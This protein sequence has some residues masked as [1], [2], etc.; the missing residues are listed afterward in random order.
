MKRPA[1][2]WV[3]A[4]VL[5]AIGLALL[6][7]QAGVAL[8]LGERQERATR[9]DPAQVIVLRTP[10]GYLEVSALV[11]NEEFGWRSAYT[12]LG[13]DCGPLLGQR[14]GRIRVPV[15]YTWRIPLA[16]HWTLQ[17]EGEAYVLSVPAPQPLL[18]PG[19]D[20]GQAEFKTE[21]GG[22]LA[23]AEAPNQAMLLKHL[24]PELAQRAQRIEYLRAQLPAAEKTVQEFARKWMAEQDLRPGKPIK[25]EF[26]MAQEP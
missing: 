20:V 23:P 18:P 5:A 17:P 11:K 13:R 24:G 26:R 25:V 21:K 4:A 2:A 1:Y 7:R 8:S 19:I 12:C 14:T 9:L 6:A 22:L 16:E 15:H 10:G 3:L